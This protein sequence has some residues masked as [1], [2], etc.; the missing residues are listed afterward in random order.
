MAQTVMIVIG[1]RHVAEPNKIPGEETFSMLQPVS[2]WIVPL[3]TTELDSVRSGRSV[4]RSGVSSEESAKTK[5][6]FIEKYLHPVT[7]VSLLDIGK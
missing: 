3:G 4:T 7:S 5:L 1:L 2:T 6:L